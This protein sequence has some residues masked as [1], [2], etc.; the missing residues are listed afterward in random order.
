MA[1]KNVF[2]IGAGTMGNGIAQVSAQAG[3]S[4]TMSDIKDEFLANGMATITRSLDR[5]VKKE[6]IKEDEKAEILGRIATTTDVNDAKDADLVIE[7][8]PEI[9]ELKQK[10]FTQ[11]DEVCKP[12]AILATNTS[13]LPV[14]AIAAITKRPQN[15]IGI[16]FM[17]PV[18]VMKGVEIIPGRHTSGDV[19]EA[20]KEY[21]K[22]IGKEPCEARDYAGFIVS[23]LVDAIINEAILCVMDGNKPEEVDKAV[24]LCLNHPMGPLEL[25]D[26]AGADVVMHGLETMYEEFGERLKPAP[27]LRNMVRSGDLGRKT[28]RGFYDYS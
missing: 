12:E 8:A 2:V 11:L 27:L 7:A 26:L 4:V 5:L 24:K 25:C 18:P 20:A 21:I 10:L 19:L 23:R 16:H 22:S 1:I 3:Y 14:G 15:V 17:N 9:L 28:G 6:T 13:S